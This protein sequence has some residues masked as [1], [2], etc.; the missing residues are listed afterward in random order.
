M[1][2]LCTDDII[3]IGRIIGIEHH[4]LAVVG[5][6]GRIGRIGVNT[7]FIEQVER[8][9]F[10]NFLDDTLCIGIKC[11][12]VKLIQFGDGLGTVDGEDIAIAFFSADH[13]C[14][15]IHRLGILRKILERFQITHQSVKIVFI[16]G[17]R[18]A[19]HIDRLRR[20]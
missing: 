7:F 11:R 18:N 14:Q 15:H 1:N 19:V 5:K 3:V 10:F 17:L 9:V 4:I 8:T 20:I 16:I 2:G 6:I 12:R 13:L